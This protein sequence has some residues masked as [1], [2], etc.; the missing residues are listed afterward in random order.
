MVK[1]NIPAPTD[2]SHAE[3]ILVIKLGGLGEFVLALSA[4]AAIHAYHP[5]AQITLMT[6]RPFVDLARQ[7]GY[8]DRVWEVE[9]YPWYQPGKWLGLAYHLRKGAYDRV[10]DLEGTNRARILYQISTRHMKKSWAG[11]IKGSGLSYQP[12]KDQKQHEFDRYAGILHK[13]GI[14]NTRIPDMSW[15]D[16]DVSY[17]YIPQNYALL[18]PGAAGPDQRWPERRYGALAKKLVWAGVTPVL[19]GHHQDR[20]SIRRI[21]TI[22]PEAIDLSGKTTLFEIAALARNATCAIANDTGA[23]HLIAA[24]GCPILTLFSSVSDP[25]QSAPR[26]QKIVVLQSDQLGDLSVEDVY[27]TL[28]DQ[29]LVEE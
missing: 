28:I 5:R 25:E 27:S 16:G 29:G 3:H 21:C 26:G 17:F 1:S 22:C 10:Y 8:F 9:R 7:S 4:M 6:T 2:Q 14:E 11:I 23:A 24:A 13:A 18:V 15:M 20:D 19:L 12:P